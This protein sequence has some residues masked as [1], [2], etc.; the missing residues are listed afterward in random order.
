MLL[1][2]QKQFSLSELIQDILT[3]LL[4]TS[5]T[6]FASNKYGTVYMVILTCL[7]YLCHIIRIGYIT[8]HFENL[9]KYMLIWELFIFSSSMWDINS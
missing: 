8:F 2:Q 5:F 7:I 1:Y 6:V 9:H 3:I 4:Y